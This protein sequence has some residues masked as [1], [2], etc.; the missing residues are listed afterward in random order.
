ML[1]LR[2]RFFPTRLKSEER[3]F[4][5]L[6]KE[7]IYEKYAKLNHLQAESKL[8]KLKMSRKLK[9]F[10]LFSVIDGGF[11]IHSLL[12]LRLN[13][14]PFFLSANK[15]PTKKTCVTFN[16]SKTIEVSHLEED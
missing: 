6:H 16:E 11:L 12:F 15:A 1:W 8:R 3:N 2:N 4:L 14:P 13:F 5:H 7:E 10:H 9:L